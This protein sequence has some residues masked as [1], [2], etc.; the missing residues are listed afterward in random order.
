MSVEDIRAKLHIKDIP[1]IIC[2]PT[3][4]AINKLREN[5]Y[6]NVAAIP[7]MLGEW[8]N[9]HIGLLMDAEVY[10]NVTT[11][12]YARP[13]DPGPYAHHGPDNSAAAQAKANAIHK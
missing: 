11:A 2:E 6:K 10:D 1:R 9:G 12:D 13:T 7:M 5:L 4:K 8:R 3:Y